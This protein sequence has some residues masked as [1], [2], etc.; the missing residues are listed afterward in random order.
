M[1]EQACAWRQKDWNS[2]FHST[3]KLGDI[4]Q[5][6]LWLEHQFY[7]LTSVWCGLNKMKYIKIKY[8]CEASLMVLGI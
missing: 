1:I 7:I 2:N 3:H 5:V 4:E 6:I 8:N